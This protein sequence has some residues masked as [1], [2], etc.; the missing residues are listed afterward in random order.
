MATRRASKDTSRPRWQ[1]MGSPEYQKLMG[2]LELR[3]NIPFRWNLHAGLPVAGGRKSQ[4]PVGGGQQHMGRWPAGGRHMGNFSGRS[5]VTWGISEPCMYLYKEGHF[6]VSNTIDQNTPRSSICLILTL[7]EMNETGLTVKTWGPSSLDDLAQAMR[8]F[9]PSGWM[10]HTHSFGPGEKDSV[11]LK[12]SSLPP[13][14]LLEDELI[15]ISAV[16]LYSEDTAHNKNNLPSPAVPNDEHMLSTVYVCELSTV[17]GKFDPDKAQ[18]KGLRPGY[19]YGKLQKGESVLSDDGATMVH[20]EDVLGPSSPGPIMFVVDCPST[21]YVSSLTS[22][23]SL[24][25]FFSD[26]GKV[27]NCMIHIGPTSVTLSKDYQ[28]WMDNF[29]EAHHIMAQPE[30]IT[31]EL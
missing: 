19:K 12:S 5:F 28:A 1:N 31:F 25:A 13:V 11:L 17:R 24:Q 9:V 16:L 4:W 27:V 22:S 23:T 14:V 30:V 26:T 21:S 29:K 6:E 2:R 3:R 10:E 7:A 8:V 18:A 20:P 15:K